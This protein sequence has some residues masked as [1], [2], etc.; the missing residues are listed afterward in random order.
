MRSHTAEVRSVVSTE[1]PSS[2]IAALRRDLTATVENT[3]RELVEG[4]A[5]VRALVQADQA[6]AA[7]RSK[8]S[9]AGKDFED[10]VAD[11]VDEWAKA[12][13]DCVEHVGAH[14]GAGTTRKTGDVVVRVLSSG[15]NQPTIAIEAKRRAKALTARQHREELAEAM[16]VRRARAA[17]AVVP[18]PDQVPGPGRF[19]RV[20][21]NAWV[22]SADDPELLRLVLAV[23]RELTLLAT[24]ESYGDP[25]LDLGRAQTAIGHGVQLLSRFDEVTKHTGAAERALTGIRSTADSLRAALAAQLQEAARALRPTE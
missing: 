7:A 4:L 19:H 22:V 6:Q 8:S 1:N 21:P 10:A 20:D 24:A 11:I 16:R 3:R 17:L 5:A 12:T 14:P 18:T 2:P 15:S 13:G 25:A 23:V 9:A